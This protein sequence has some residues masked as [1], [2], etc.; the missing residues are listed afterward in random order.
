MNYKYKKGE[1]VHHQT[2]RGGKQT[3]DKQLHA[4]TCD[5][6]DKLDKVFE[7]HKVANS[8]QWK[9]INKIASHV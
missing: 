9:Q 6:S 2:A 3:Y 1:R 8:Q 5:N 7:K 4:N